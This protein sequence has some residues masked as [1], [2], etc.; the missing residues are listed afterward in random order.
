VGHHVQY[1]LL[2]SGA[3][4][5][6]FPTWLAAALGDGAVR[7][8]ADRWAPWGREI[9]AD[10]WSVVMIGPAA[11][12]ALVDLEVG[13]DDRLLRSHVAYP[14][15]LV[16]FALM[17]GLLRELG[18]PPGEALRGLDP[19]AS[20]NG[21]ALVQDDRDLRSLFVQDL[22]AAQPVAKALAETPVIGALS[23]ADLGRWHTTDFAPHGT[24]S[25]WTTA[26]E[27]Q[28]EPTPVETVESARLATSGAVWAWA[29]LSALA[30]QAREPSRTALR[31]RVVDTVARS[32]EQSVRASTPPPGFAADQAGEHLCSLVLH[33]APDPGPGRV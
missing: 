28:D 3:L 32:R 23:F 18:V 25:G 29:N 15:P 31:D 5:H 24:T 26:F 14:S 33:D 7:G 1:D 13:S 12:W 9:F 22:D 30:E 27:G 2:P 4:V 21:P 19:E 17:A 6:G 16:R 20:R 10:A 11:L 8:V